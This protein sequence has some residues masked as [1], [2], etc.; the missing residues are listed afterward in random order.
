MTVLTV[1]R[2]EGTPEAIENLIRGS[3]YSAL[4]REEWGK[5][6]P[7]LWRAIPVAVMETIFY[8]LE[9]E[10]NAAYGAFADKMIGSDWWNEQIVK[11]AGAAF[12]TL[13]NNG[14]IVYYDALE[15]S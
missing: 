11:A 15:V 4:I 10:N 13:K 6:N 12:Q 1:T 2:W 8:S 7:R 3:K 14:T 9:F 5:Q